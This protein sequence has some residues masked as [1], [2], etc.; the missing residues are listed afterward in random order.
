LICP[1]GVFYTCGSKNISCARQ[2]RFI[3][4]EKVDGHPMKMTL[5]VARDRTSPAGNLRQVA[6]K[7]ERVTVLSTGLILWRT[8]GL[9]ST[10]RYLA[11]LTLALRVQRIGLSAMIQKTGAQEASLA[12]ILTLSRAAT[13]AVLAGLGVSEIRDRTGVAG[14]LSWS[15]ILLA[16]TLCDWLDGPLARR[17]GVTRLGSILDIEAD[18]WLTLWSAVGA[19][20][21]GDLP[22][23]CLLPP[24]LRYLDPLLDLLQGKLPH[25]GGPWWSRL[26]GT[27]QM[28]LF[29]TA[30]APINGRWREKVLAVAAF[31]VSGAQCITIIVLLAQKMLENRDTNQSVRE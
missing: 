13:G 5:F 30:L 29:L 6:Q 4:L 11:G 8:Y 1:P 31:P 20:A 23:W 2:I 27:I 17:A 19:V 15:M 24:L 28:V 14:R 7:I 12:D 22:R 25:G 10:L 26:T 21:W 3:D 18:S 9:R 16:A